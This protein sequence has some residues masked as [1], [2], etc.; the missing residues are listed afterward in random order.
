MKPIKVLFLFVCFISWLDAAAQSPAENYPADPAS[1]D[2]TGVPKG[3]MMEFKFD[4]SKIF[5][6]TT[7]KYWVY[8]PAAYDGKKPACLYVNQDGIQ[9]K[10]PVVFDNIFYKK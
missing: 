1:M 3:D 9:F 4:S 5:P 6:G 8:V 2:Q 7:R 10:A